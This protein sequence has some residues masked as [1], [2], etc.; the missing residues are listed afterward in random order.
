MSNGPRNCRTT[1]ITHAKINP[2]INKLTREHY[3][4]IWQA[5]FSNTH[6]ASLENLLS[7]YRGG[8]P[9]LRTTALNNFSNAELHE[10]S[11]TTRYDDTEL[12]ESPST[13]RYSNAELRKSS[14]LSFMNHPPHNLFNS[15]HHGSIIFENDND[16]LQEVT[17]KFKMWC[18]YTGKLRSQAYNLQ[19]INQHQR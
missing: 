10:L 16:P 5:V 12:H 3:G 7:L 8:A 2:S 19:V 13:P 11:T 15:E 14:A 6:N 4:N 17:L 9:R 1:L 18:K